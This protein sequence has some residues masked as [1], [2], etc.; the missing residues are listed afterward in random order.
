MKLTIEN[1]LDTLPAAYAP[2]YEQKCAAL[3]SMFT[4]VTPS[5][6]QASML[7]RYEGDKNRANNRL[8]ATR[9]KPRASEPGR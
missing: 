9:M 4:R 2:L 1:T 3:L 5:E 8:Q 7:R 6:T